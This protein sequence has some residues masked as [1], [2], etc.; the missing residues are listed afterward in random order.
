M[1]NKNGFTLVEVLAVIAILA[2][3]ALFIVP[4]VLDLFRNSKKNSFIVEA[5]GIYNF[6]AKQFVADSLKN[7]ETGVTYCRADGATCT[8]TE[9]LKMTGRTN[10]DYKIEFDDK[11]HITSFEITDG[12]YQYSG[13]N[14]LNASAITSTNVKEVKELQDSEIISIQ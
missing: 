5:Q 9:E 14:L 2:V 12:V 1:K 10:L 6:A 7:G 4:N 8:D 13:T 11:G 3:L